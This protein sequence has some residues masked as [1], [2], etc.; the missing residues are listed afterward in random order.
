MG[1]NPVHPANLATLTC[2]LTVLFQRALGWRIKAT[3]HFLRFWLFFTPGIIAH[4]AGKTT[5]KLAVPQQE[6]AGGSRLWEK[7]LSTFPNC[8]AVENRSAFVGYKCFRLR[9]SG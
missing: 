7:I 1:S 8:N 2:N 9:R 3:I 5:I 4:P 6:R